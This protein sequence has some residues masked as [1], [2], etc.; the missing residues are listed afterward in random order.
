MDSV[1]T[2]SSPSDLKITDIR[3]AVVTANYDYPIIKID[4]NQ[5]VY[6][7]G[8]VRDFYGNILE[9][10]EYY[11]DGRAKTSE[12]H[13]G[14]EKYTLT[15]VNDT[16]TEV[17]DAYNRLST[18]TIDSAFIWTYILHYRVTVCI[19]GQRQ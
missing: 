3:V 6:G 15:Y 14:A 4:T 13:G 5:G 19:L 9:K 2:Y 18:Y 1:N 11:P 7:I 16:T 8:E 10:H 17:R 12:L